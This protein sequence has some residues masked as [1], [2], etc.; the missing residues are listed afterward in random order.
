MTEGNDTYA[1]ESVHWLTSTA[2]TALWVREARRGAGRTIVFCDGLGC[3]GFV[4][5]YLWTEFLGTNHVVHWNYRGH[6]RSEVPKDL[7]EMRIEAI[8]DDLLKVLE[9]RDL[10]DVVLVGHSMGVQV[11]LEA[12]LRAPLGRVAAIVPMCGASGR[13]LDTF[14]NTDVGRSIF[15]VVQR[16]AHQQSRLFRAGWR[17]ILRS[18]V[19][20]QVARWM[21]SNPTLVDVDDLKP[22]LRRLEQSDPRVF[23]AMVEGAQAHNTEA[24]LVDL[25]C[26]TLVV[27]AERDTFTPMHRSVE[28]ADAIDGAEFFL[29]PD[30]SHVGPLEWPSF[31]ALRMR[32]FL[33]E[34]L[35]DDVT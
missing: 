1:R 7:A 35:G 29:L 11:I 24:R 9:E 17:A 23:L 20:V 3:D 14:K 34:R 12:A 28:L 4:W 16:F 6:G 18:K 26:P 21:E 19:A 25:A 22:Y 2:G 10:R 30:A 33:R 27:A 13:V 32:R 5:K 15:P 8:A 31:V